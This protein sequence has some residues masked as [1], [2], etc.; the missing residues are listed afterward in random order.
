MNELEEKRSVASWALLRKLYDNGSKDMYLIIS[1]F[2]RYTIYKESMR[3]FDLFTLTQRVNHV[4]S[5][6]LIDAVVKRALKKLNLICENGIFKCNPFDYQDMVSFT[7]AIT[8]TTA[9]SNEMLNRLA[10][11]VENEKGTVLNT[12]ERENL[13]KAFNL[14]MLDKREKSDYAE[15]IAKFIV[16]SSGDDVLKKQ[17][18][19]IKEGIVLY[20]GLNYNAS[21]DNASKRWGDDFTVFLDTEVL[22]HMAGFNGGTYKQL[23]DDF[24]G[25]INEINSDSI[26]KTGKKKIKLSFFEHTQT[27]IDNFFQKAEEIVKGTVSLI[28]SVTA[29]YA[30]TKGCRSASDV[31]DR[32]VAFE[33]LMKTHGITI[34]D[35]LEGY[36]TSEDIRYN[37]ENNETIEMFMKLLPKAHRKDIENSLVSL[38]HIFVLR[39]GKRE[40]SFEKG[41][42]ILLTDNYIT[43]QIA[44]DD[45]IKQLSG[46]VLCTDLYYFTDRLWCRLGKTFGLNS[47]PKAYDVISR[48][49]IFLSSRINSTITEEYEELLAKYKNKEIDKDHVLAVLSELRSRVMNPE[50]IQTES[51]VDAAMEAISG[52]SIEFY[53]QEKER[54]EFEH[55]QVVAENAKLTKK[56]EEAHVG[57]DH[58]I[59]EQEAVF[60]Q[61]LREVELSKNEAVHNINVK[62]AIEQANG[63]WDKQISRY[64]EKRGEIIRCDLK[65]AYKS[66]FRKIVSFIL[67]VGFTVV[68]TLILESTK[69]SN[70]AWYWK[71]ILLVLSTILSQAIPIYRTLRFGAADIR[72]EMLLIFKRKSFVAKRRLLSKVPS[73]PS[74]LK[75]YEEKLILLERDK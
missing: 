41:K 49:Q 62:L 27:E 23:F 10:K 74:K 53:I 18:N 66:F 52:H 29:M 55:L 30:I 46:N 6:K 48:A 22:F 20:S 36:Y 43:R 5:I 31:A 15:Y 73:R 1:D 54:K 34:D 42:Y 70:I 3:E 40:T 19:S 56:L 17:L 51:N 38:S 47:S 25:M 2:I 67:I 8:E 14:F 26:N 13:M 50:D 37:I 35:K 28:P 4:F 64:K 39:K 32:K 61:K 7:S 24:F 63:E 21:T 11:Y 59:K 68:V 75:L 72:R 71:I 12:E 60:A 33:T 65:S 45:S 58:L 57:H 16:V 9:I 44:W 69:D